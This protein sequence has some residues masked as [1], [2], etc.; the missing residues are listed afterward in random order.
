MAAVSWSWARRCHIRLPRLT[1]TTLQ[2]PRV[3]TSWP[4]RW[5]EMASPRVFLVTPTAGA[6]ARRRADAEEAKLR[7]LGLGGLTPPAAHERMIQVLQAQ[8]T[9]ED[10]LSRAAVA[11]RGGS[12]SRAECPCDPG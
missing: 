10:A 11:T 8:D 6:G 9:E 7:L 5:R 12:Q 2:L 4:G 1:V 3:P